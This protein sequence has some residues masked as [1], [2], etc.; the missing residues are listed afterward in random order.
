[1]QNLINLKTEFIEQWSISRLES[2]S[3]QEYTNHDNT[4]F[5]Y[6]VDKKTSDLGTIKGGSPYKFGIYNQSDH[7]NTT[8]QDNRMADGQFAW[9][10]RRCHGREPQ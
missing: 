7:S 5:C 1:M 6:W 8:T 3:L 2:M 9:F 4:S 10:A